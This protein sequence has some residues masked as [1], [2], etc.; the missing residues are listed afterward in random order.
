[1]QLVVGG[2]EKKVF[3]RPQETKGAA[4]VPRPQD[5]P[6]LGRAVLDHVVLEGACAQEG[7]LHG[8]GSSSVH[9]LG[10]QGP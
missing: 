6:A 4:K 8:V 2:P 7:T 10:P 5:H 1:M 3:T 9:Y